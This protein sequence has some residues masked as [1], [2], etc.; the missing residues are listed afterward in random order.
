MFGIVLAA[1]GSAQSLETIATR[2][3][4]QP[5]PANRAALTRYANAHPKDSSGALALLALGVTED[6]QKQYQQSA[7]HLQSAQARL[8]LLD[9]FAAYTRADA[10]RNMQQPRQAL[11]ALDTVMSHSPD[12]P[13]RGKAALLAA[14][15]YLDLHQPEK[16]VE[17]IAA[18]RKEIPDTEAE[19][20]LA[21]ALEAAGKP[22]ESAG[23]YQWIWYEFPLSAEAP[24]AGAALARLR[25]APGYPA[26]TSGLLLTRCRKLADAGD[27]RAAS[28]IEAAIPRMAAADQELARIKLGAIRYHRRDYAGADLYLQSLQLNTPEA[29]AER[30]YY[31]QLSAGRLQRWPEVQDALSRLERWHAQS[32]WRIEALVAAANQY[33]VSQQ[34][35]AA[36]PL[37]HACFEGFPQDAHA[38]VCHWK[39]VWQD[40]LAKRAG[41]ADELLD[42][43][44]RFPGSANA[45]AAVYFL[46][47]IAESQHDSGRA[48][49]YYSEIVRLYPN[50]YYGALARQRLGDAA[51]NAAAPSPAATAELAALHLS[52][53]EHAPDLLPDAATRPRLERAR[54]LA[55]AGLEDFAETELRFVGQN[56]G[57]GEV[58]AVALAEL[59]NRLQEPDRGIRFIKHYAPE[60]LELPLNSATE[61]LW[62]LAFP[63]P[64]RS[65]LEKDARLFSLDPYLVAALIRQESEFNPKAVSGANAYGLAQV[66]PSTGR[67]VSRRVSIRRFRANMLFTPEVNLRIGTFYMRM[68]L[69][70][71]QDRPEAVLASYNAG[72]SRVTDWLGRARFEEPAEFVESIPF[73]ETRNYVE[74]VLRNA[75]IYRRLYANK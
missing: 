42:H 65:A 59:A 50:Y 68:L 9:D 30:L 38:A 2:F 8:P 72:K 49:A 29:D 3:R 52:G 7:N 19:L 62:K 33:V 60:Y 54:L 24:E 25:S 17:A 51:V 74:S 11:N 55:S 40:Y 36:L 39:Y 23:H 46:A 43:T 71:L 13:L 35:Q 45:P 16:A 6:E 61:S 15:C 53:G 67:M 57:Q 26:E 44:R 34:P 63:I 28:E 73:T 66:M 64:Y 18:H 22:T 75:D 1:G 41:A 70:Q 12:S 4:K 27:S 48:R 56:G 20:T 37:Y 31:V 10:L 5:S 47:R 14:Q 58:I 21:R 69:D 32:K